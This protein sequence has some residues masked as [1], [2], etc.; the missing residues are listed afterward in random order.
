[1]KIDASHDPRLSALMLEG[2]GGSIVNIGP[3][4]VS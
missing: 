3:P 4:P 2:G 1:V